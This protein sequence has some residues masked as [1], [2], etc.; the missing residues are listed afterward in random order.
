MPGTRVTPRRPERLV[1]SRRPLPSGG[2]SSDKKQA[3]ASPPSRLEADPTQTMGLTVPW[4]CY[5]SWPSVEGLVAVCSSHMLS[6][7]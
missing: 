2:D 7:G 6:W 5:V 1:E 3:P 4:R